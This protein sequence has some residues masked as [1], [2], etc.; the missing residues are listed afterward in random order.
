[1][2]VQAL[3]GW[4]PT[5]GQRPH[6]SPTCGSGFRPRSS[7]VLF[8]DVLVCLINSEVKGLHGS[9]GIVWDLC[10]I[11]MGKTSRERIFT[12]ASHQGLAE[13]FLNLSLRCP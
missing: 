2:V 8:G 5:T 12:L 9:C 11:Q 4:T 3:T 1:M 6:A 10:G 13:A 7:L